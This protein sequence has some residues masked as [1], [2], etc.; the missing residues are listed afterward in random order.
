MNM[1]TKIEWE[2]GRIIDGWN[3]APQCDPARI[4]V[5]VQLENFFRQDGRKMCRAADLPAPAILCGGVGFV[6]E[7][8]VSRAAISSLSDRLY[9]ATAVVLLHCFHLQTEQFKL[10]NV[11]IPD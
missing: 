10:S 3:S 2:A 9:V 7:A 8:P 4:L 1:D 5:Q 6:C 11:R